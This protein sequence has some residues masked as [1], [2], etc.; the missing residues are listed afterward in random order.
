M[1]CAQ[2]QH[3]P[4][5]TAARSH[6]FDAYK[7]RLADVQGVTFQHFEPSVSAAV[8]ATALRLDN[9]DETTRDHLLGKMEKA[10]VECRPGFYTPF[11]QSY[12]G[13]ERLD[14]AQSVAEQVI[15]PPI[16]AGLGEETL[17]YICET[18]LRAW[19]APRTRA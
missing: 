17:D 12:P 5:I 14:A 1:L 3:W 19:R 9:A 16:D 2:M 4:E 18:F 10:G 13:A 7:L 15:V 6:L 11:S 8:W